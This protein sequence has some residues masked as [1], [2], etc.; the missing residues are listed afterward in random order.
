VTGAQR[1]ADAP[2]SDGPR[3][4]SEAVTVAA[5]PTSWELGVL[6]A[7]GGGS[8]RPGAPAGPTRW[9]PDTFAAADTGPLGWA[10]GDDVVIDRRPR[11][12]S[13]L[14]LAAFDPDGVRVDVV[15]CYPG[16]DATALHACAA[17]GARGL[18]RETTGAGNA[19]PEICAAVAEFTAGG[20]VV[21]TSTRVAAGPVAALY[22][23]AAASTCWPQAQCLPD[24]CVPARR[25]CC[26]PP[27][28][29]STA[30]RTRSAPR[31]PN[32]PSAD[33]PS[34]AAPP[35][36]RAGH[37]ERTPHAQGDLLSLRSRRR[38]GGGLAGFLRRGGL[39]RRR[40]PRD[41]RR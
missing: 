36:A 25:A 14:D 3:D 41:V 4:L 27:C 22:G 12:R 38:R 39:S 1:S 8:S 30:T 19:N 9:P 26:S 16:A 5:A 37:E 6:V 31:S 33:R 32:T 40:L 21:V 23:T 11:R 35:D 7:S 24:P 20:V 28:G 15:A 13:A 18:V 34:T 29:T 10:H 17:A 2:D